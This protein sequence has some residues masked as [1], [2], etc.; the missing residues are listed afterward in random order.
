M[1]IATMT[2]DWR[3]RCYKVNNKMKD[4]IR[5]I[6]FDNEIQEDFR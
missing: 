2:G 6:S 3:N 4:E 5:R 1:E